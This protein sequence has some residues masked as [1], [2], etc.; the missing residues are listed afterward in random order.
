MALTHAQETSTKICAKRL[1]SNF[2]A[3]S[4]KFLY[5]LARKKACQTCR[6]FRASR[7]VQVSST[8]V[9]GV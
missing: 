2:D 9:M 5:K 7:L 6:F 8:C 1:A 4:C 3:G